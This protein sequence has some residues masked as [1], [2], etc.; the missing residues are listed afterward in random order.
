MIRSYVL[1]EARHL[2]ATASGADERG[3][4]SSSSVKIVQSARW[5]KAI[6]SLP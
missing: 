3:E 5:R 1:S 6:S 4:S 2:A